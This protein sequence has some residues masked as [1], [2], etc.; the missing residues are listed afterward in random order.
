MPPATQAEQAKAVQGSSPECDVGRA[1]VGVHA[2]CAAAVEDDAG[3][4]GDEDDDFQV[5]RPHRLEGVV[6]R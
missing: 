3:D 4:T 2:V 1:C 6:Q 5:V